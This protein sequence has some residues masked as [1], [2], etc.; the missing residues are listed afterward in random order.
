MSSTRPTIDLHYAPP[1]PPH[2]RRL[3]ARGII[4]FAIILSVALGSRW[5]P[6]LSRHVRS[7]YWQRQC[8]KHPVPPNAVVYS[9]QSSRNAVSIPWTKLYAVMNGSQNLSSGTIYLG[10]RQAPGGQ[11]Y[12]IA[13][14]L[15]VSPGPGVRNVFYDA[16]AIARTSLKSPTEVF[17]EHV[18][19]TAEVNK[20]LTAGF[21]RAGTIFNVHS[22]VEDSINASH[23][24]FRVELDDE[25]HLVD[26]WLNSDGLR[27]ENRA[28][29]PTPPPPS[30]TASSR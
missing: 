15:F 20:R 6:I 25:I 22:G 19:Q 5:L 13:V 1:P 12:L 10:T 8:L 26:V 11:S 23:L 4:A 3:I 21:L 27:I 24:S 28:N 16:R 7:L 14:D 30:S 18:V 9:W 2:K 17:S 29:E